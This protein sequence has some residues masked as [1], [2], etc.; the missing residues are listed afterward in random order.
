[1]TLAL[2][3]ELLVLGKVHPDVRSARSAA[4]LALDNGSAAERF[5][6]MVAELGG[7]GEIIED[8]DRFLPS[9]PVVEAIGS[10]ASGV[11][12][13]IDVR[14]VGIAIVALGGGR[15][16]ETDTVDHSVGMT[17]VAALGEEVGPGGRPL[18][19]VHARDEA[20][21]GAAAFMLRSAFRVGDEPPQVPDPVI[22]VQ[23]T[24]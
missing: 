15:A 2:C 1:V 3:A 11:V 18:A 6:A 19:V 9:A 13:A 8:P 14:A 17:E 20:S 4:R 7:P 22:E 21:I 5:A 16:T 24:V 12:T 10:P 23:R